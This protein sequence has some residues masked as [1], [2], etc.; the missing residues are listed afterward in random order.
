MTIQQLE[1]EYPDVPWY[2]YLNQILSPEDRIE[3]DDK[4]IVRVP[5][6]LKSFS[7][8][9]NNTPKRVLANYAVWRIV[10]SS[11][12]FMNERVKN[13]IAEFGAAVTGTKVQEPRWIQCIDYVSSYLH[14]A[15]G[16]LYV[17]EYFDKKSKNIAE[18]L[19]TGVRKSFEGLLDKVCFITL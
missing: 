18:E 11:T 10:Q 12:Y 8:L 13:I 7:K 5:S 19:V 17:R 9:I 4:I 1:S 2:E 14:L 16:A 15:T 6:F 3:F